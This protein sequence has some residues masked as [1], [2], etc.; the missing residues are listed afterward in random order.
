MKLLLDS[1]DQHVGGHGAPD[2][3]LDRV[4]AGAQEALDPQVLLDPLERLPLILHS[5]VCH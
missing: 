5:F 2:L 4:L 1:C 3:R